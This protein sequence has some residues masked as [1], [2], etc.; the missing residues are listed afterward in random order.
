VLRHLPHLLRIRRALVRR[1]REDPPALFIG[2]DAP[3]FNLRLERRLRD[4][5]VPT[6]HYVS[7]TVW[8]WRQGRIRQ[9]AQSVDC[10]LCIFPF[11]REFFRNHA[12]PATFVGH[13]LADEIPMTPDQGEARQALGLPADGPVVALLPGSRMSEA[14]YLGPVFLETA[15]W[16]YQHRPDLH[17][18][19]PC[20]T[21]AIAA[22][23]RGLAAARNE[24][25]PISLVDGRARESLS[26]AT[27]ALL[28][29]GTASLEAML[30]KRPMVVAYKVSLLTG[31][32]ARYLIKVPHFAMP[33]LIADRRMVEEFAQHDAV[34]GNLGPAVLDLLEHPEKRDRLVAE[35]SALHERLRQDASVQAAE[36]V[37]RLLEARRGRIAETRGM[38]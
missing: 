8:A 16:L 32:L 28:A 2:V 34:P 13:P 29:S 27:V 7:P 10:M 14:K 30:H 5:G 17:F 1:F 12:V 25:M 9:I 33:N 3:D 19:V 36:A 11:E 31:W 26:A 4:V 38:T 24:G 21:D 37:S 22:H 6:V 20:A 23:M 35:F 18:I 15:A